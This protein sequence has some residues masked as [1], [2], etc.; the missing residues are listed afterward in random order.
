MQYISNGRRKECSRRSADVLWYCQDLNEWLCN[1]TQAKSMCFVFKTKLMLSSGSKHNPESTR[2]DPASCSFLWIIHVF[3]RNNLLIISSRNSVQFGMRASWWVKMTRVTCQSTKRHV[4]QPVRNQVFI[5]RSII[6][7][8]Q[9]ACVSSM[10]F[11]S[12]F[13]QLFT[14][15][16]LRRSIYPVLVSN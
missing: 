2:F 11:Q 1:T 10:K 9:Y 13:F 6:K 15:K 3:A 4:R 7:W 5:D 8:V 14:I 16:H 12:S